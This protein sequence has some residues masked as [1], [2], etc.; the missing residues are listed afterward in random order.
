MN[1]LCY[2]VVVKTMTGKTFNLSVKTSDTIGNVRAKIEGGEGNPK[3][4]QRL[5]FAGKQVEYGST[6]SDYKIK[7]DAT[8]HLVIDIKGD[9]KRA[10][11]LEE[12][13][14]AED[15]K[16]QERNERLTST[17]LLLTKSH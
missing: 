1:Q 9:G 3:H 10:R 14:I 2:K 15:E 8:I 6:L 7:K 16:M 11:K 17:V 13:N 5:I 4:L 12:L